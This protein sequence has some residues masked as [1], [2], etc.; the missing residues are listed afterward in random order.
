M[1]YLQT[2]PSP[3][4][5]HFIPLCIW[6]IITAFGVSISTRPFDCFNNFFYIFFHGP[7]CPTTA[8]RSVPILD[9]SILHAC[10]Y[11]TRRR[12][13]TVARRYRDSIIS[14]SPVSR[15]IYSINCNSWHPTMNFKGIDEWLNGRTR[16]SRSGRSEIIDL[17]H[18]LSWPVSIVADLIADPN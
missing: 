2:R 16:V 9:Q 4:T 15:R 14:I 5:W 18:R 10:Q 6:S 7:F 12:H 17:A 13:L 3:E 1:E 11:R 8:V